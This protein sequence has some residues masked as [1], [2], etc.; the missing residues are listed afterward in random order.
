MN[1]FAPV[2][3]RGVFVYSSPMP[4]RQV[5]LLSPKELSPET[6]A[7]AFAKTS[8][9]P[10]S[11]RDIAAELS[12]EKSAE[13]HEKWVVGYGHAS[14]AEHAILHIAIENVSR[15]AVECIESNRLAS[16][17]EKSTRYQKWGPDD[18]FVPPE[19]DGHPLRDETVRTCRLLFETY[20][21]SLAPVRAL[22]EKHSKR[23]ENES[24]EAYDRR[25]RSQYVD[26]CRFL[27]PA[28]SLA[29]LGMTANARVLENAIRKMLSHPLAEVRQIGEEVKRVAKAET[30]TLVKYAES[31][32]YL[33]ETGNNLYHEAALM[34]SPKSPDFGSALTT[35]VVGLQ[36]PKDWLTLIDFDSE[37]EMKVLAAALYRFGEMPFATV[38]NRVRAMTEVERG[39]LAESLLG[40]MDRHDTPLRELEHTTYSFDL[41]LDQG[42][43][44]EFKRHR[45]MTQTPQPLTARLGYEVPRRIAEAGF[46]VRYRSTMDAAA[47]MYEKLSD[48]NPH[49]ASYIVPNG[50]KRRVLFT[51]NL[52][53]AYAFCQLRAAANA[54][55]SMRRVAQR[56]AE[57]IRRVHPLLAKYMHLPGEGWQEIEEEYL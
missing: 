10:E 9:S 33:V 57:E 32:P 20:A 15:L 46:E 26:S 40:R 3:A 38:L 4:I 28:A 48:W 56:V 23:R 49:V 30:P 31:V 27:L 2:D 45:M 29:N 5:Y 41:I 37:G 36:L 6:I 12:N 51:M 1:Q 11:F 42:G 19:L 17:T 53:E 55:F 43:Y 44:A 47:A 22:V 34:R 7:V 14:V 24:D 52:R 21:D 13:F 54:H 25:I 16:Y 8:R 18:F 39:Q 35:G 50:F